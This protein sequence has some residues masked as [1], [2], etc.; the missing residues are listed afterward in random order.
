MVQG[1]KRHL[2]FTAA[3]DGDA[4]LADAALSPGAQRGADPGIKIKDLREFPEKENS[5][6]EIIENPSWPRER[7]VHGS[8]KGC[9]NRLHFMQSRNLLAVK[10]AII[11][12]VLGFEIPAA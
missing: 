7:E 9:G 8:P 5:W 4:A 3:V 11:R 10:R 6:P 2:W 12:R 1:G